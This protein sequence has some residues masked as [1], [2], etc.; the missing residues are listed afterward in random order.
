MRIHMG[1]IISTTF[2]VQHKGTVSP[3]CHHETVQQ[4]VSETTEATA[5]AEIIGANSLPC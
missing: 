3:I 1:M 5:M 2:C 4:V